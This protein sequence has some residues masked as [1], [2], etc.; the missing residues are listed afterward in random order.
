VVFTGEDRSFA[1]NQGS[2]TWKR[3]RGRAMDRHGN[4]V[5]Y[6]FYSVYRRDD[7]CSVETKTAAIVS[8]RCHD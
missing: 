2:A 4:A 8:A 1:E 6:V 3:N 5:R 7:Q